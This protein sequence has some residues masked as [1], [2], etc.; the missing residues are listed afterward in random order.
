MEASDRPWL[1]PDD[2]LLAECTI[3]AYVASG[4]GGQKRHK[5][6]AAIRITHNPTHITATATDSRSQRENKIHAIRGLRHKLAIEIRHEIDPLTYRPP[7]FLSEYPQLHM[8]PRNPLYPELMA[9]VLDVL[10]ATH[11]SA[12]HAAVLL[13]TSTNA[14]TRFLHDDP[15][16]WITVNQMRQ[17]LGMKALVW[18]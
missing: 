18:K 13:G 6:N 12:G 14:L 7:A 4:P 11:W 10:K 9:Q 2:K 17:Q 1:L 15:S 16:L 5:T 8:N 3:N